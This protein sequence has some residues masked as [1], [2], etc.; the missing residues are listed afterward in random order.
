[1]PQQN[2]GNQSQIMGP[3]QSKGLPQVKTPEMN[4]RDYINEILATEK[5]LANGYNTAV[6]EASNEQLYQI[7]LKHL[8]QLHQAQRDLFNLM[9]QQG[10]YKIEAAP[11]NQISQKAQ[12]FANYRTQFPYSQ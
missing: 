12:Q 4:D 7:Q 2:Q 11:S 9:H 1:V 10:W 8:T 5:Y 6:N 3:Q